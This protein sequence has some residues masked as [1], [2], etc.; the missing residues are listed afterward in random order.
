[1]TK[2]ATSEV[3]AQIRECLQNV[4][5]DLG[6]ADIYI[7]SGGLYAPL[8]DEVLGR[9]AG[10]KKRGKNAILFLTTFGGSADV[11]YRIARGFHRAYDKGE[12]VIL[13]PGLCKSAGTLL[14]IGA[15]KLVMTDDAQLGP[16]DVQL[17]KPDAIGEMMSGLTPC[18]AL[19]FLQEHAFKLFEYCLIELEKRS[20]RQVTFRTAAQIATEMATGLFDD[21]YAQLD[22][23]RLGEYHRDMMVA[24]EYG[25]RLNRGNLVTDEALRKL[26]HGYPSHDFVIDRS[27]AKELFKHVDEPTPHQK[28]L[29]EWILPDIRN[30]LWHQ[31]TD[32]RYVGVSYVFN[33][34]IDLTPERA[35][36]KEVSTDE[37]QP[38]K[39]PAPSA[40]DATNQQQGIPTP[41]EGAGEPREGNAHPSG[42]ASNQ[43]SAETTEQV[44]KA[45]DNQESP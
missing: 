1:M 14:A 13:M 18:Q 11:A 39:Q 3:F 23:M 33:M 6:G 10:L 32:K 26:T 42:T 43:A 40:G 7:V 19:A 37:Q 45:K 31:D 30:D 35:L 17:G 20:D 16:L 25:N 22:P 12:F 27:E 2:A 34:D 9:I 44:E 21:V 5:T 24:V 29:L 38:D 8:D 41:Q 15:T 28:A 36:S 4:S